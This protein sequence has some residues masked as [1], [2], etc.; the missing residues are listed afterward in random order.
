M[1]TQTK[2]LHVNVSR[3]VRS[4]MAARG[5]DQQRT[6]EAIGVQQPALSKRL[7]GHTPWTVDDIAALADLFDVSEAIFFA[8][9]GDLFNAVDVTTVRRASTD[10]RHPHKPRPSRGSKMKSAQGNRMSPCI[11]DSPLHTFALARA[12]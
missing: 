3:I 12:A 5:L 2:P 6:A 9:A 7:G 4:L 10:A 11:L 8:D 1:R